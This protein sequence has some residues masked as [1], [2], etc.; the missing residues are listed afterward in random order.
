MINKI[1]ESTTNEV[2]L[3]SNKDILFQSNGKK[4]VFLLQK[5][6]HHSIYE[7]NYDSNAKT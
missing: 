7:T 1:T 5:I 2:I 3:G 6:L 4:H